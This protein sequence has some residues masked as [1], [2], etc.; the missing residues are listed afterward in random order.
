MVN[1]RDS[2]ASTVLMLSDW[3]SAGGA[4]VD[5]AIV[6]DGLVGKGEKENAGFNGLNEGVKEDL[7]DEPI[8]NEIL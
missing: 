5:A 7:V 1:S 4:G 8:A 3:P 2:P 6:I